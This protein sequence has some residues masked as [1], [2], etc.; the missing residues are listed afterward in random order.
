MNPLTTTEQNLYNIYLKHSRK[1]QPWTP[2]KQFD[3]LSATIISPL[4][5]LSLFLSKYPQINW[6]EYF[7]APNILH[8]DERYPSLEVFAS[9]VGIRNYQLYKKHLENQSPETH[10]EDI[11]KGLK[12]IGMFCI[13]NKIPV[14]KYLQHKNGL[15]PSW[16][17]HYREHSISPYC[18]FELGT[19]DFY[20]LTEE[21]QAYW[22]PD[23]VNT[24]D[25]MKTRYQQS[26]IRP[27]V[28]EI[29]HKIKNFVSSELMKS[30]STIQ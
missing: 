16:T 24:L 1:G 29:T 9:R 18:L 4:K 17:A 11:K 8:K 12:F 26:P 30:N 10:L 27:L 3:D 23:L 5:K 7:I 6:D 13:K 19:H 25:S 22:A 20:N 15:M 2:R 14:E 28:K 21:E